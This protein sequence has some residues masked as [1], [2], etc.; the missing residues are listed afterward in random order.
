MIV[1][2]RKPIEEIRTYLA[3]FKDILVLGCGTCATVC[4]EGGEKEAGEI[5]GLLGL[6]YNGDSE[7][8]K[9]VSDFAVRLCEP[10]FVAE[11]RRRFPEVEAVLSLG[12][13]AGIQM[14]SGIFSG[15]PVYP[16][17]NTSFLGTNDTLGIFSEKCL[18][19]G[20]CI[21]DKTGGICPVA[22]CSKNLL[23]GP[24]GGSAD[25]HCEIN[26]EVDCA[27][28]LIYD[29]MKL[30]GRLEE[31]STPLPAKDWRTARDGGP[32]KIVVE[33]YLL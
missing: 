28:Q 32:R 24:C 18:G 15:V 16:G 13:G 21:L 33:E 10:E 27:W 30:L 31:L 9:L 17:V 22:R 20:D 6:V 26:K 12:C 2:K 23:N 5:A 29:R 3:G 1:V 4:L 25:G 14:V 11:V 19:C 7:N 8:V